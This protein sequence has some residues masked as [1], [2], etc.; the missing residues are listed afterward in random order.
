MHIRLRILG[1]YWDFQYRPEMTGYCS[2]IRT[3]AAGFSLRKLKLAASVRCWQQ[4]WQRLMKITYDPE[5]MA[6]SPNKGD[7]S[8]QTH[9][10]L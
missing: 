5:E 9:N 2:D 7:K 1:K 6:K 4:E 8:Q 3:V 10:L